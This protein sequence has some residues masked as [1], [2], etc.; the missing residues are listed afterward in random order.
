MDF[1]HYQLD[2]GLNLYVK[3][4]AKF[5]TVMIKVFWQQNLDQS[6]AK[7]ALIAM[8]LKRGTRK[9]PDTLGLNRVLEKL[10]GAELDS[11]VIK[12]GERQLLE[13]SLEIVKDSISG[14]PLLAQALQILHDVVLDPLVREDGFD[15]AYL[16]QEKEQLKQLID[17]I[18]NDKVQYAVERCLEETGKGEPFG[19]PRFGRVEE[20]PGLTSGEL[21]RHYMER[22]R[23]VPMDMFI[24]GDVEPQAVY[25]SVS[26]VFNFSRKA[27][28]ILQAAQVRNIPL[29]VKEIVERQD[30]NQGKL[31]LAYR[32]QVAYA[33]EE[34]PALVV[35][36]GILG[37]F[38]HSKLFQNVREKASLAY[39]ASSRL[40]KSKG[41]ML[42]AS[43]IESENY[44]KARTIIE[45]QVKDMASGEISNLELANT[46]SALINQLRSSNDN[47][48]L[49][50]DMA[51]DGLVNNVQ[52]PEGELAAKIAAVTLEDV[53]NVAAGIKLD[54]VYFLTNLEG[55]GVNE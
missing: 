55:A 12:K 1:R 41:I 40:E 51:V 20:L 33:D 15:T 34:Y 44:A 5:K 8:L 39:Y 28:Y 31:C 14:E 29:K 54:T 30:I 45:E 21:Y 46:K 49:M 10:Y 53:V 23:S 22:S 48:H 13:F 36:N 47:Y 38:A 42:I 25:E 11:R 9:I 27:N 26:K 50:V 2:N 43:G 3:P 19:I 35:Y 6:A 18:I 4:T 52:R 7:N 37:G 16:A 32:T 24:V 17:S